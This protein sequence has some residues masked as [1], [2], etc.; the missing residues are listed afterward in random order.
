MAAFR[1]Q[2]AADM[3]GIIDNQD[4]L[5]ELHRIDATQD[6]PCVFETV[7]AEPSGYEAGH[8]ITKCLLIAVENFPGELF[9]GRTLAVDGEEYLIG[10]FT[11]Y[12]THYEIYMSRYSG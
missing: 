8:L 7:R 12:P 3:A 1:E 2:L 11:P 4:E 9:L 5:G 10:D 6:V